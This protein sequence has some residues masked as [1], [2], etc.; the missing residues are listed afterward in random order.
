MSVKKFKKGDIGTI[1]CHE[2]TDHLFNHGQKVRIFYVDEDTGYSA[3][4]LDKVGDGRDT[5]GPWFLRDDDLE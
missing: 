5:D 2:L 3:E 4:A 1:K